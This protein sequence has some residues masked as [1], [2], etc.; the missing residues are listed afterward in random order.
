MKQKVDKCTQEY[1]AAQHKMNKKKS[2]SQVDSQH[3][4]VVFVLLVLLSVKDG[5]ACKSS[6]RKQEG[7]LDPSEWLRE[8]KS[9]QIHEASAPL[10][11][12]SSGIRSSSLW[13][14]QQNVQRVSRGV[15]D[16]MYVLGVDPHQVETL[17]NKMENPLTEG[18]LL[19]KYGTNWNREYF[20]LKHESLICYRKKEVWLMSITVLID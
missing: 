3:V 8:A 6:W 2:K 17:L 11:A 5:A 20:V 19:R 16:S 12:S 1:L 13:H 15:W 10:H 9:M 14:L 18:F 7:V 4:R